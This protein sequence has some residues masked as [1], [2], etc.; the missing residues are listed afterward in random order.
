MCAEQELLHLC[1]FAAG[2]LPRRIKEGSCTQSQKLTNCKYSEHSVPISCDAWT[3]ATATPAATEEGQCFP[4]YG[5]YTE[6]SRDQLHIRNHSPQGGPSPFRKI[7][8]LPQSQTF[9]RIRTVSGP[10][11]SFCYGVPT[12]LCA[13]RYFLCRQH[14]T[15]QPHNLFPSWNCGLP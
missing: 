5:H 4:S 2:W 10:M 11:R 1:S 7:L 8:M 9:G 6:K 13:R 15:S 12:C 3:P 14:K